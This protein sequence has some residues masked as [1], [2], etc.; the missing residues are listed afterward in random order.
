MIEAHNADPNESYTMG[1]NQFADLTH[2]EF[3]EI[4]LTI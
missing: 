1:E 4:Y 2:E 3:V